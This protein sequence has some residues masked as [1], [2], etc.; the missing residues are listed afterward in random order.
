MKTNVIFAVAFSFVMG[1]VIAFAAPQAAKV[2]TAGAKVIQIKGEKISTAEVDELEAMYKEAMV[3]VKQDRIEKATAIWQEH[4]NIIKPVIDELAA[5]K[6]TPKKN[7]SILGWLGLGGQKTAVGTAPKVTAIQPALTGSAAQK[8]AELDKKIDQKMGA[9]WKKAGNGLKDDVLRLFFIDMNDYLRREI[10]PMRTEI[11]NLAMDPNCAGD[12]FGDQILYSYQKSLV[13]KDYL[14]A[15]KYIYHFARLTGCLSAMQSSILDYYLHQAFEKARSD[16]KNVSAKVDEALLLDVSGISFNPI[17]IVFDANKHHGSYGWVW[18]NKYAPQIVSQHKTGSATYE[19]GIWLVDHNSGEL[20]NF[21]LKSDS[22]ST[23]V[24]SADVSLPGNKPDY[25]EFTLTPFGENIDTLKEKLCGP[26]EYGPKVQMVQTDTVAGFVNAMKGADSLGLGFTDFSNGAVFGVSDKF[27][28]CMGMSGLSKGGKEKGNLACNLGGGPAGGG[29]KSGDEKDCEPPPWAV[30]LPPDAT[31]SGSPGTITDMKELV[32]QTQKLFFN[33]GSGCGVS[34]EP[35]EPPGGT[36]NLAEEK[37][38]KPVKTEADK[39]KEQKLKEAKQKAHDDWNK[40]K[41][42]VYSAYEQKT[43]KKLTP[44]QKA[45][46]DKKVH[47]SIDASTT[48]VVSG[49]S[50]GGVA[51]GKT[52]GYIDAEGNVHTDIT[53]QEAYVTGSSDPATAGMTHEQIR[54][55]EAA[56]AAL[57]HLEPTKGFLKEHHKIINSAGYTPSPEGGSSCTADDHKFGLAGYNCKSWNE[58]EKKYGK[59][60][61]MSCKKGWCPDEPPPA[62]SAEMGGDGGISS[63]GSGGSIGG[64]DCMDPNA[65]CGFG[66]MDASKGIPCGAFDIIKSGIAITDPSPI[67]M[68]KFPTWMQTKI[69]QN[70]SK[71][72]GQKM[73]N[74]AIPSGTKAK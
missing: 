4:E 74:K 21:I 15:A 45:A 24:N 31:Q 57:F 27:G 49:Q 1:S 72:Q 44:E 56:H 33:G 63:S 9:L 7:K 10:G 53:W 69:L 12:I 62:S 42:K 29:G 20:K 14:N 55:H 16:A 36:E 66:T 25:D 43:G 32:K 68:T 51:G 67:D 65:P 59:Y 37:E 6:E 40:N 5:P 30:N 64:P 61:E 26:K 47:A 35:P 28:I 17:V 13:D 3:L 58:E 22:G 11:G 54:T 52:H 23:P 8:L 70:K 71:Q 50:T 46:V 60:S 73:D 2:Q 18:V 19:T 41:E 34:D 38:E 39:Q 48:G